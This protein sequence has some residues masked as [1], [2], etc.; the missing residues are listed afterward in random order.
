MMRLF[1]IFSAMVLIVV[2]GTSYAQEKTKPA[3]HTMEATTSLVKEVDTFHELLHPLVHDAYP[4][5]DFAAIKKA[6]PELITSAT[7]MKNANLPK[8]LSSKRDQYKRGAKKLLAQLKE[9]NKKKATLNDES[10]G[11]K[12]MEMHDTFESIMDMVR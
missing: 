10:L 1:Q 7:K 6:L 5:K 11:K 2:C 8:G 12:F 4:N 3:E 9:L